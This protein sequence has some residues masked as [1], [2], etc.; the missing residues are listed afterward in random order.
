MS[1]LTKLQTKFNTQGP[2]AWFL[3]VFFTLL[4][5][6]NA[7]Y[8]T[9]FGAEFCGRVLRH[10]VTGG[11]MTLLFLD[12]AALAW[13]V[14]RRYDAGNERQLQIAH[15]MAI[16][17]LAGSCVLTLAQIGLNVGTGA[18]DGVAWWVGLT[19]LVIIGLFAVANFVAA[20]GYQHFSPAELRK[21]KERLEQVDRQTD[22]DHE[23]AEKIAEER[24]QRAREKAVRQAAAQ[25]RRELVDE[26]NAAAYE[27]AAEEIH[28]AKPVIAA[29]LAEQAK[30]EYFRAVGMD[31]MI[32]YST[33]TRP[34][35]PTAADLRAMVT[36]ELA[37]EVQR[38]ADLEKEV[39]RRLKAERKRRKKKGADAGAEGKK[40]R[41][42]KGTPTPTADVEPLDLAELTGNAQALNGATV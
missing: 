9:A 42:V 37:R 29:R 39:E 25:Q 10:S 18:S 12:F 20:Y 27:L 11:G 13:F 26:A 6:V 17:T 31:D 19:G 16:A 23:A 41:K 28:A 15:C 3:F 5:L 40:R 4:L 21:E 30:R 1:T 7:A 34:A 14:A 35:A 22:E 33:T 32:D 2:A 24:A 8:T 38:Q 36:E